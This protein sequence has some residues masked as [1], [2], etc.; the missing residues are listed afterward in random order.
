MS[1]FMCS[2]KHI[3]TIVN[4]SDEREFC[5]YNKQP[6]DFSQKAVTCQEMERLNLEALHVRYRD[7][8]ALPKPLDEWIKI[9]R[10]L[11]NTA[12][13]G[14]AAAMA[15]LIGCFLYQCDESQAIR[16]S[17]TFTTMQGV[18][19]TALIQAAGMKYDD[20]PWSI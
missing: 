3:A 5:G 17:I 20:A 9:L 11:P 4:W 6:R 2:D 7:E 19:K 15:K 14:S 18:E 16:E 1:S 10:G 8:M 12:R 13:P